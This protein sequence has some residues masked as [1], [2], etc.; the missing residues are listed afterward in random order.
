[1][2]KILIV[3]DEEGIRGAL[4][5]AL[6]EQGYVVIG[7]DD[8]TS[9]LARVKSDKPDLIIS[10][11]RMDNGNGFMLRELLKEDA[12]T[13]S[14][15]FILMTGAAQDAGAWESEADVEYLM[16]PFASIE[17]IAAVL[18]KLEPVVEAA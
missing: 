2:K 1:M 9:G 5:M 3:D 10:D 4:S 16:K 17:L 8:C 11:V 15:P 12:E 14:I 7:A 6:E 13:G 18:R